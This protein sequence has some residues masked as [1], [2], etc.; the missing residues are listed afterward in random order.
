MRTTLSKSFPTLAVVGLS[1]AIGSITLPAFAN[2]GE[3]HSQHAAAVAVA[4]AEARQKAADH[5]QALMAL[6]KRWAKAQGKEKSRVL[7]QLVEKA[8]ERKAFLTKLIKTDPA[9]VLR[10]AIPDTKQ[11]GMPAAV[12]EQLEQK[13]ELSGRLEV[14][15]VDREDG[16]HHLRHTLKTDFGEQFDMHF[17]GKAPEAVHG[18]AATAFGVLLETEDEDGSSD[19]LLALGEDNLVLAL[20][21]DSSANLSG[22]AQAGWTFGE[23]S[24]LVINVNFA[25]NTTQ[26]WTPDQA[27]ST[28]FGT[29]NDFIK[30][31]SFQQT[32]LSGKVTPW[33]R[34]PINGS[35]CDTSAI[36]TA[37][38]DAAAKAGYDLSQYK[39]LIYAMPYSSNCGFSGVGSVGGWPSSMLLNGSMKWYTVA[40]EMG[41]NL[42]LYHSHALECGSA[43]TGSSCSSDEYGDGVDIMGRVAGHFTSFQKERLGWLNSNNIQTVTESGVYSLEPFAAAQGGAP[44]ALKV[45]NGT[46]PATGLPAWYYVEYRGAT[47]FDEIF[48]T[49]ANVQ[50]GV[51]VHTGVES[52]GNTSYMLDMTPGSGGSNYTDTRDP[53]L[54]VGYSFDD[55]DGDVTLAT[56][57]ADGS[58]AGVNVQVSGSVATCSPANPSLSLTPGESSWVAA[59]TSFSYNLTLTNRDSSAC[60]SN[61]F[62]LSAG[63]PSGW[64]KVLG[65][66]TL[67]LAPG[68]SA[69]TTLT[70]TSSSSAADGFY[71]ISVAAASGS[72]SANGK[73]TYVV[74]NP[75]ATT[76][77]AP[78]ANNDSASTDYE[79]AVT[80]N[81]LSNDSDPDGDTLKVTSVSGVNG[82]AVINANGSITFTPANGFS[83]TETFSYTVSDGSVSDNATVSVSVAAAS[84]PE[85][86]PT[87]ANR[88]PVAMDDSAS[89]D[90]SGSV[91]IP[92]LYNDSDP[93]GNSLKV[94]AVAEGGKGS[95][96][97]NADGTLT[98][99]PAKNFKNFDTFSYT[100]SDG[101][102][103]DTATVTVTDTGSSTGGGKGN[104]RNK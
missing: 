95:V 100:I 49:N 40:H 68:E 25:D 38:N 30:Q 45:T 60:G 92:V 101:S 7:E 43:V 41:H 88:A 6:Q 34:L 32:W 76:N 71:T 103:S 26:P 75:D 98:F 1:A 56:E 35:S 99:T 17:A 52:R 11:Q 28:V 69:T 22:T 74:D 102:L 84:E 3:E 31:N 59:G 90:G 48:S 78:V 16:S 10:V 80:I 23:Q 62:S 39:R 83:G 91:T 19:G 4:G 12:L 44:K 93:D 82:S 2:G 51:V 21:G 33:L 73:V 24:T 36:V 66:S 72:Y 81:V 64:S 104:G 61:S 46:D 29:T 77:N 47:G 89:S 13:L 37:A 55:R 5:T 86:E 87:P 94:V 14:F 27:Q 42:G 67:T 97:I 53:A 79:T 63:A 8:K 65:N 54:E 57:W 18:T 20:D 58:T 15:Y 50:N 96:R 85:P 9:A 70:V